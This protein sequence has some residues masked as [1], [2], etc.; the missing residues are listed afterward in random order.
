MVYLRKYFT[1]ENQNIYGIILL[2]II[3]S[4]F[5]AIF[6]VVKW[7]SFIYTEF[8]MIFWDHWKLAYN[9]VKCFQYDWFYSAL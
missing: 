8:L 2:H 5:F 6:G 1:L 9:A 3:N 4:H 7:S